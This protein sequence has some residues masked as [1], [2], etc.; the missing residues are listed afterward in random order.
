MYHAALNQTF[1]D[2]KIVM[3]LIRHV[4]WSAKSQMV[5]YADYG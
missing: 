3:F 4:L 2:R 5:D 1:Y